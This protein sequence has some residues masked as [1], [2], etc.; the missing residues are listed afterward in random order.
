MTKPVDHVQTAIT[1]WGHPV[2]DWV[3]ALALACRNSSQAKVAKKLKISAPVVSQTLNNRY[4]G[5]LAMV[6][7]RVRGALMGAII[8]C[9]ELGTM[10]VNECEEWKRRAKTRVNTNTARVQMLRACT[11]CPRYT[12]E[13]DDQGA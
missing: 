7:R 9:P 5:D 12:G 11:R 13:F 2:P 6:E 8:Q 4:P 10:P 1:A 3:Q